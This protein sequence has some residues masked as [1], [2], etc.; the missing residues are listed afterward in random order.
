MPP[1]GS[2]GLADAC[3]AEPRLGLRAGTA[4]PPAGEAGLPPGLGPVRPGG[5][6]RAK[7][8][9]KGA[10]W[11]RRLVRKRMEARKGDLAVALAGPK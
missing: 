5:L 9:P 1:G 7:K 10:G 8:L 4:G 11:Q 3:A 6:A 2:A